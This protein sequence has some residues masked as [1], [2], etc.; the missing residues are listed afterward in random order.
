[1]R[2][3]S[4]GRISRISE[5][6]L[7]SCPP[8][9]E[10]CGRHS[11]PSQWKREERAAGDMEATGLTPVYENGV[12]RPRQRAPNKA[13]SRLQS[14]ALW[15]KV[16]SFWEQGHRSQ[17][18]TIKVSMVSISIGVHWWG[19]FKVI[20]VLSSGVQFKFNIVITELC[21]TEHVGCWISDPWR[22]QGILL[23]C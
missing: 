5:V 9:R 23:A 1:M 19:C 6:S 12:K 18:L 4:L 7:N 3:Y 21:K 14:K 13:P 10:I 17:D 8:Q 2:L 15:K 11:F 16:K 22:K 20:L